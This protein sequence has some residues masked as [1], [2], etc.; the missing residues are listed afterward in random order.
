METGIQSICRHLKLIVLIS[1]YNLTDT[2]TFSSM[3]KL[4]STFIFMKLVSVFIYTILFIP[5]LFGQSTPRSDTLTNESIA[6]KFELFN[7]AHTAVLLFLHTDKTLYIPNETI[8]FNA[9]LLSK[10]NDPLDNHNVLSVVLIREDGRKICLQSKYVVESG[11]AAGSLFLP[12]TIAAGLYQLLAYTNI[13]D[14]NAKPIAIFTQGITIKTP[15]GRAPVTK[16]KISDNARGTDSL[17]TH[18]ILKTNSDSTIT[19]V[20]IHNDS[21]L[22][23]HINN[24]VVNDTLRFTISSPQNRQVKILVHDYRHAYAF[25]TINTHPKEQRVTVAINKIPKGIAVMTITDNNGNTL[26]EH[27]FFAHFDDRINTTLETD[28]PEY[29][30]KEKVTVKLKLSDK[31]GNP[32]QGM[33]SVACAQSN[34]IETGTKKDIETYVY[35]NDGPGHLPVTIESRSFNEKPYFE[36]ILLATGWYRNKWQELLNGSPLDTLNED[37]SLVFAGTVT[38]F[39]G[40]LTKSLTL[41]LVSDS[42]LKVIST[43]NFGQFNLKNNDLIVAYGRKIWMPLNLQNKRAYTIDV[44]DP[45]SGINQKLAAEILFDKRDFNKIDQT[46]GTEVFPDLEISKTLTNVVVKT[47]KT[48]HPFYEAKASRGFN[49]NACGDYAC[50]MYG[51]LNCPLWFHDLTRTIIPI[52]G[53]IYHRMVLNTQGRPVMWYHEVYMGCSLEENN[54][55]KAYFL[56]G[57]YEPKVFSG[58]DYNQPGSPQTQY[59][60]TLFWNPAIVVNNGAATFSFITSDL[61]GKFNIVVQGVSTNFVLLGEISF[62]VK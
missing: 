39:N 56:P 47:K 19:T 42:N 59:L 4:F 37:H 45:Y 2:K 62:I 54:T 15:G 49:T 6:E 10:N 20:A 51:D 13:V 41:A 26:A 36:K 46:S 30:N 7:K 11:S 5:R 31:N 33:V 57:I 34:R 27:L 9:Y 60:S 8:W 58:A 25:F 48:D 44:K 18:L 28:K 35:L 43:D 50:A 29:R 17:S 38:N 16:S 14:K 53:K 12:D 32:V 23:V 22:A 21:L 3:I 61:K 1:L 40:Q 55:A 24:P 52:K